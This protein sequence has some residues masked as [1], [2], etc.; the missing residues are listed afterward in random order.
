MEEFETRVIQE[1]SWELCFELGDRWFDLVRK[2]ILDVANKNS[3][4][5]LENFTDDDYLFPIPSADAVY[6]GQNP[7]YE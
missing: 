1:R 2:R 5:A 3:P 7:G 6:I 4:D